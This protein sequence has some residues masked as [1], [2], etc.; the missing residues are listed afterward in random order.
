LF[1]EK[2]KLLKEKALQYKRRCGRCQESVKFVVRDK[3]PEITFPI[4]TDI[5]EESGMQIFRPLKL[6]KTEQ[7]QER[8]YAQDAYA[9][10][11]STA[12]SN[13]Y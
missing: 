13:Y 11:K 2:I 5:P 7:F 3:Y 9:A 8:T 12:L 10:T 4:P 6:K 1:D